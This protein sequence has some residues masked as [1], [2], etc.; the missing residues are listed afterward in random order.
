MPSTR[1]NPACLVSTVLFVAACG[2]NPEVSRSPSNIQ[3]DQQG[4]LSE[5]ARQFVRQTPETVNFAFDQ[6]KLDHQAKHDIEV[7]AA[8]ILRNPNVRFSIYG[9]TDK[10]GRTVYNDK[11]GLL[12]AS[13]VLDYLVALGINPDRLDAMISH[14][15]DLPLV[16]TEQRT[17]ENRRV[18]TLVAGYF[19]VDPG[20]SEP[21][22]KR[23][24]GSAMLVSN[25]NESNS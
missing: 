17:R 20:F 23:T 22:S 15:E 7:Q 4:A 19:K 9:H 21:T 24:T 14:G 1:L 13:R 8:W 18:T 11:L 25:K 16:N 2:S 6:Y 3:F 12:R 5:V 10:V